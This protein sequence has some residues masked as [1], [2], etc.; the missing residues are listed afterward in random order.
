MQ[1]KCWQQHGHGLQ[2]A[3]A[4]RAAFRLPAVH[5]AA[6]W[7]KVQHAGTSHAINQGAAYR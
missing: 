2:Q 6:Q 3:K 7:Q 1:G 5:N 4:A